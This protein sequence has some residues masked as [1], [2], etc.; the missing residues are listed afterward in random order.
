[1]A[2]SRESTCTSRRCE[3]EEKDKVLELLIEMGQ[4]EWFAFSNQ[5]KSQMPKAQIIGER[6]V[7]TSRS[8]T[9]RQARRVGCY[10]RLMADT[11][12]KKKTKAT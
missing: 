10:A 1:M 5:P 4:R 11:L 7:A 8:T 9:N 6:M 2:C 12:R 3:E